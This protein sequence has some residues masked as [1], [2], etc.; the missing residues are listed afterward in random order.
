[1]SETVAPFCWYELMTTDLSAAEAF[2]G[3]VVGW[4][5]KDSGMSGFRYSIFSMGETGIA[6][7]M[8]LPEPLAAAGVSPHWIGYVRVED[9][10]A[11]LPRLLAAGGA[12]LKPAED[13]PGVGR[14]AVVADPHGAAF[15]L[16]R[17]A[18]PAPAR[19]PD[20]DPYPRGRIGWHELHAGDGEAA[21]AFYAAL[22]GWTETERMDMGPMGFYRLFAT[23]GPAVGG[24]MTRMPQTPR[25]FW[26][27]YFNV[28]AIDAAIERA[29]AAGGSVVHGP[30]EV[31]GGAWIVQA[32]DPQG[33]IFALVAPK[34]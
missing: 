18:S 24:M 11:M 34:R 16:F 19:Q 27:F 6:G 26:A 15:C 28:E 21:F 5:A 29:T 14:F 25:P 31:P 17:E 30:M 23:G 12:V 9:V 33:A 22:F 7:A 3:G 4:T 1:M 20:A 10:D 8:A 2:Y 32:I 13:I